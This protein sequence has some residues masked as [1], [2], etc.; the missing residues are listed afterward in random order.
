MKTQREG[1]CSKPARKLLSGPDHAH[2]TLILNF[3]PLELQDY[4]C[5]LFKPPS[6]WNF[7]I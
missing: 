1:G 3:Q 6:L 2:L 4:K 5:L 7:A